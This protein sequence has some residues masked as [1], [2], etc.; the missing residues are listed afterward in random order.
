MS[1][2]MLNLHQTA[3]A[4]LFT[5]TTQTTSTNVDYTPYYETSTTLETDV[6]T[7]LVRFNKAPLI[8]TL[9]QQQYQILFYFFALLYYIFFIIPV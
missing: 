6:W 7:F 1:R 4:G 2:L 8:A 5:T 9:N 3:D